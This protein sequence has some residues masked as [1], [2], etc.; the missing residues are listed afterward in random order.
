[1]W[2]NSRRRAHSGK[3]Y[4]SSDELWHERRS[5]YGTS[6]EW[7]A[8]ETEFRRKYDRRT[9][10]CCLH[11]QHARGA[12]QRAT[13]AAGS[14]SCTGRATPGALGGCEPLLLPGGILPRGGAQDFVESLAAEQVVCE[15]EEIIRQAARHLTA[16]EAREEQKPERGTYMHTSRQPQSRAGLR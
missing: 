8:R 1:M 13:L 15:S 6:G 12:Q 2:V 7:P 11:R 9:G 14:L 3:T 4:R 16:S 5:V 10:C